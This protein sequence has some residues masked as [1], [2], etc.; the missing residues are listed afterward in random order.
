MRCDNCGRVATYHSIEVI[1]GNRI[2]HHLCSDCASNL[3]EEQDVIAIGRLRE[4]VF[5]ADHAVGALSVLDHELGAQFLF[6][7]LGDK[8]G[9][10]IGAAARF[11]R[12]DDRHRFARPF[13]GRGTAGAQE[14]GAQKC[15][16]D[17]FFHVR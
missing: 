14:R 16:Q 10:G 8:S 17:T 9:S 1:N 4:V 6:P 13:V 2:E 7:E 12:N 11:P 3:R 15:E 5:H